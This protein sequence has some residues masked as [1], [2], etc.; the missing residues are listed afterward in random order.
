MLL[1]H[2]EI[3]SISQAYLDLSQMITSPQA[4]IKKFDAS[5]RTEVCPIMLIITKRHAEFAKAV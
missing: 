5:W 2:N 4:Q 3:L 1:R